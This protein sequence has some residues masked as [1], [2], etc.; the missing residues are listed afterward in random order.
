MKREGKV[1]TGNDKGMWRL[2]PKALFSTH[3]KVSEHIF[4]LVF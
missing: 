4:S 3:N 2:L 1:R